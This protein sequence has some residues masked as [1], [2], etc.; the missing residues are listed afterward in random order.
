MARVAVIGVGGWGKNHARVMYELGCLAAVCD[1]DASRAE[2]AGGRYGVAHYSSPDEMLQNENLDACLV[3]TPTRTHSQ[4][5]RKVMEKG[6]HAFV[7]KPLSFSSTE[8]EEMAETAKQ[9]RVVLTS[10]YIERFN[11]AVCETKKMISDRK[12]GDLLMMEF[13]RENRMPPHIKDV[14]II[15]DTS[16]HDIDT[17]MYLFDSKPKVVFARSGKMF[18]PY[19]DF[20]T[21]M[22]GFSGQKVAIIASNW[23]TPKKTRTFNAVCTDGIIAGDF[24]TQEVRI[25][26]GESTTIPRKQFQEPLLAELRHFVDVV[27][28]KTESPVV[29]AKDASD[30][31]K[32]AE[33]AIKSCSTGTPVNLDL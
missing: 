6:L 13:H 21:I 4:V 30:V 12:Y 29:S 15:Y 10:G 27:D 2:E 14:G 26:G 25:E 33:A 17:A 20:A 7:E 23:I 32:V 19:E 16:V 24:L 11:P 8:C 18:N 9:N 28:G 22:L 1:M 5:A 31:T 3:C